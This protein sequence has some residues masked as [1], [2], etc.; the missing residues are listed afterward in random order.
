[1][2]LLWEYV[3]DAGVIHTKEYGK[4]REACIE[5]E[6]KFGVT[7]WTLVQTGIKSPFALMHLNPK[8]LEEYLNWYPNKQ[9]GDS[10][11]V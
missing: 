4:L 6:N 10:V 1:L 2:K 9:K 3:E 5:F 8:D 7:L 11:N